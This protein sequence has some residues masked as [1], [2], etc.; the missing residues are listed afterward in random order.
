M[1]TDKKLHKNK[2]GFY[3][4]ESVSIRGQIWFHE[5]ERLKPDLLERVE[6]PQAADLALAF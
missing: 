1:H 5:D 6:T 4:R 3:Q 2:T